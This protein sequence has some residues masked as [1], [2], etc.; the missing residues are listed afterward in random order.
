MKQRTTLVGHGGVKSVYLDGNLDTASWDAV[1]GPGSADEQQRRRGVAMTPGAAWARQGWLRKCVDL[2]AKA[3]S[4]LPW[5]IYRQGAE[6]DAE[7]LWK[8]DDVATPKEFGPLDG[9]EKSLYLAEASLALYGAAYFG[10]TLVEPGRRIE[11]SKLGRF[12][13]LQYYAPTSITPKITPAGISHFVRSVGSAQVDVLPEAMLWA[14]Q[15]DPQVELGVGTS[16]AGAV[17]VNAA[18]LDALARFTARH[19]DSGLIK[20]TVLSVDGHANADQRSALRRLWGRLLR[21]G[22][23]AGDPPVI[24]ANVTPHTIG[25]GFKDLDSEKLTREMRQAIAAGLGIPFSLVQGDAANFATAQVDERGFYLRTVIPQAKIIERAVNE[26]LL[27]GYG[28]TLVF[29]PHRAD[30]MM[31]YELE[32]AKAIREIVA[33]APLTVDEGRELMGYEPMKQQQQ[34][35]GDGQS[36]PVPQVRPTDLAD[37][38]AKILSTGR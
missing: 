11:G 4:T 34:A 7:P 8:D 25:E 23:D 2:R 3:V 29:E 24:N 9:I 26:H 13:G 30:V 16:D 28:Y 20:M 14:F 1:F 19:V 35:G 22:S 15:P 6:N 5:A 33:A 17:A 38:V 31:Q 36:V 10:K 21:S 27:Q 37:R 18:A 12:S 32:R